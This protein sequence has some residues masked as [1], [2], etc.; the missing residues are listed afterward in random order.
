MR[1]TSFFKRLLNLSHLTHLVVNDVTFEPDVAN[2]RPAVVVTVTPTSRHR[3]RC[4]ECHRK[5]RRRHGAR[6]KPRSWRHLGLF[7]IQVLLRGEVGRIVCAH[8]GVRTT[9]VPWS[10]VGSVFTRQF[11]DEVAWFLQHTDQTATA[12]YFGLTLSAK[13][14]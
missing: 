14:E 9:E 13:I 7:G 8:C 12:A 10:R 11:E 5:T 3:R 4:G 6:V 2:Y 1:L